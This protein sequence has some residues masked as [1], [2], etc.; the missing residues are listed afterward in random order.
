MKQL[1]KKQRKEKKWLI[2]KLLKDMFE[3]EWF[4][5][6]QTHGCYTQPDFLQDHRGF[7]LD[8][9][10][11]LRRYQQE[12]L[13]ADLFYDQVWNGEYITYRSFK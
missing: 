12:D 3:P 10:K 9:L 8:E 1:T 2:A 13:D 6:Y 11:A 7:D 5:N 4:S